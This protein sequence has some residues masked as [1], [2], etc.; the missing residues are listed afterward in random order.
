MISPTSGTYKYD[1]VVSDQSGEIG[2]HD[3]RID[4]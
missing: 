1:I 2:R 4:I 3:P